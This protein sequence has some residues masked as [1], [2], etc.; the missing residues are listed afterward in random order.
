MFCDGLIIVP[1]VE[2]GFR[3]DV[4]GGSGQDAELGGFPCG[5]FVVLAV[6]V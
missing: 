5:R 1:R 4:Q 2:R 6:I 3:R